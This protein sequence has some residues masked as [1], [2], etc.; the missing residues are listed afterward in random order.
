MKKPYEYEHSRVEE[1]YEY[2]YFKMEKVHKYEYFMMKKLDGN[3]KSRH[4]FEILI[5]AD[6][7]L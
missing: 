3:M 6:K 7:L 4:D 2:R 5:F 1:F